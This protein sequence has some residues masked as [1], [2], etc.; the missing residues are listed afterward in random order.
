[1]PVFRSDSCEISNCTNYQN[2]KIASC[3]DDLNLL[4]DKN[5]TVISSIHFSNIELK[6]ITPF[7]IQN[8]KKLKCIHLNINSVRYKIAPLAD[9]LTKSMIDILSLQETKLDDSFPHGQYSVTGSRLHRKDHVINSGGLMML[10]RDDIPQQRR[11]DLEHLEPC[12]GRIEIMSV[13][14]I[15]RNKKWVLF[16]LYKQPQVKNACIIK[17]LELIFNKISH[18]GKNIM[19]FGDLNINMLKENN[20]LNNV[21]DLLGVK[22]MVKSPTCFKSITATLI[23]LLI[24]NVPKCLQN[25]T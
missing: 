9:I 19:C 13:E 22:N 7:F 10:I 4:C 1:M 14:I 20:Y 18:E 17:A 23:D 12:P 5:E 2:N 24:T 16:S 11:L 25:V 21:F 3:S 15:L 8:R 6:Q